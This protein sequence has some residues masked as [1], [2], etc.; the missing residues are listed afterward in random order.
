[1]I[2]GHGDLLADLGLY[3]VTACSVGGVA[4]R[5]DDGEEGPVKRMIDFEIVLP[6]VG[7]LE[8]L[9]EVRLERGI[10]HQEEKDTVS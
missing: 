2:E 5:I 4:A 10:H 8:R 1:M 3:Q 9:D 7:R 6:V